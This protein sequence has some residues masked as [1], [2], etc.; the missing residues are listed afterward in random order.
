MS[1]P[2]VDNFTWGSYRA[3]LGLIEANGYSFATYGDYENHERP[4][5]IRHDIDASLEAA[6]D[7]AR[8]E[9]ECCPELKATYFVLVSSDWYNVNSRK[10]RELMRE[11]QDMGHV[12]GLHFDDTQYADID[13]PECFCQRILEEAELLERACGAQIASI[14]M[15]KPRQELLGGDF[16]VAGLHN[17]YSDVF[18]HDFKYISDS[19]MHWREN[20]YE[21][22]TC[23]AY[24]RLQVLTHPIWYTADHK[25][26]RHKLAE[27][28]G[29]GVK[30]R[31]G[32]M[33]DTFNQLQ[34]VIREDEITCEYPFLKS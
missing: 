16:Q 8:F 10:N 34:A 6:C 19:A 23:G 3:L 27:I 13:D 17:A 4:C 30:E 29:R 33:D 12:I 22:I 15:H 5:I 14:S 26:V 20:P 32:L 7:M 1:Q 9:H 11:I 31:Y 2:I 21:V 28:V 25:E 24:D 18:F